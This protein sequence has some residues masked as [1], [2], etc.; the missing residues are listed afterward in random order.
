MQVNKPPS[1][2]QANP[3]QQADSAKA[4][5]AVP[6][7]MQI[8]E[9][10]AQKLGH[11]HA[12]HSH[13]EA[14]QTSIS[15]PRVVELLGKEG[16]NALIDDTVSSAIYTKMPFARQHA[17][18]NMLSEIKGMSPGQLDDLKDAI[19]KRMASPDTSQNERDVLKN[20]YDVVD[21]VAENRPVPEHLISTHPIHQPTPPSIIHPGFPPG[22][23]GPRFPAQPPINI[24][25][26][27][28][29]IIH[30][31]GPPGHFDPGFSDI[32]PQDD[33]VFMKK[34]SD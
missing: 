22:D 9:A 4:A 34:L 5:K 21:A 33:S 16:P 14:T 25:P 27:G 29:N 10:V 32:Q 1:S 12:D 28:P 24:K 31:G 11:A 18:R 23:F 7:K 8:E 2:A 15:T 17:M 13:I 20:M 26:G 3:I 30:P 6:G 19:V